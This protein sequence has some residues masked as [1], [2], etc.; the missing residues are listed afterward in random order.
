MCFEPVFGG[1]KIRNLGFHV[2]LEQWGMIVFKKVSDF[3]NDHIVNH[4]HW[5][6]D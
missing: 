3:M 1:F 6:L 2:L 4:M 5:R